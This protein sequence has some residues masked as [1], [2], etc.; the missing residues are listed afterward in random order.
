MCVVLFLQCVWNGFTEKLL[1]I[2]YQFLLHLILS[3]V[4]GN[5]LHTQMAK[6]P[7]LIQPSQTYTN[8]LYNTVRVFKHKM[9]TEQN[10]IWINILK[11]EG[12]QLVPRYLGSDFSAWMTS[13]CTFGMSD[14]EFVEFWWGLR[15]EEL[16]MGVLC[17]CIWGNFILCC[18]NS[19]GAESKHTGGQKYGVY[20]E[21]EDE[22]RCIFVCWDAA[23]LQWIF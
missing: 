16:Q 8:D 20:I 3:A 23:I 9:F 17:Q 4:A 10:V 18:E 2:Q 19:N 22:P 5:G 14:G 11:G 7:M 1:P 15:I 6:P 21:W 13:H 12:K